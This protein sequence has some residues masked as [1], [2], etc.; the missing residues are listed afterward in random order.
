MEERPMNELPKDDHLLQQVVIAAEVESGSRSGMEQRAVLAE[1]G[2][3][4]CYGRRALYSLSKRKDVNCPEC[5]HPAGENVP[6]MPTASD[7]RP[8]T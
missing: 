2:C 8:L 4:L 3:P 6:A 7:G 5:R 1:A